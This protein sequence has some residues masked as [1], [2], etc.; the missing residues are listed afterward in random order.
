MEKDT[1]NIHERL[2]AVQGRVTYLQND[3]RN[4]HQKYNFTSHDAIAE[5]CKKAM[6]EER[7]LCNMTAKEWLYPDKGTALGVYIKAEFVNIDNVDDK[8]VSTFPAPAK[9]FSPQDYGSAYSY[10]VKFILSKQFLLKTGDDPDTQDQDEKPVYEP[11]REPAE[12]PQ[13]VNKVP[14][15]WALTKKARLENIGAL[16]D[17]GIDE[18]KEWLKNHG[19]SGFKNVSDIPHELLDECNKH[20]TTKGTTNE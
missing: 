1:R 14:E 10:G 5:Y 3:G 20:F 12:N 7:V 19:G 11:K 17:G 6:I 9:S 15:A 16:A 2:L 8:V 18:V 4:T 13:E